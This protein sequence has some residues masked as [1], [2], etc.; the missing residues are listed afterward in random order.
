[1]RLLTRVMRL[2][3]RMLLGWPTVMSCS[4]ASILSLSEPSK[5]RW[6][7]SFMRKRL[8]SIASFLSAL[9]FKA[10]CAFFTDLLSF[11]FMC[12]LSSV[13]RSMSWCSSCAFAAFASL[14]RS[15]MT[16]PSIRTT[17]W[18]PMPRVSGV[19]TYRIFRSLNMKNACSGGTSSRRQTLFMSTC[20]GVFLRNMTG[21][22]WPRTSLTISWSGSPYLAFF[23]SASRAFPS[24]SVAVPTISS[25]T[26]PSSLG[27][28]AGA[29][30][31]PAWL[32][33]ALASFFISSSCF[34][35]FQ[36][37]ISAV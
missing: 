36:G 32:S 35:S 27:S 10:C 7:M 5:R 11:S 34:F 23:A 37:S 30:A 22:S 29:S 9:C 21:V 31:W 17:S 4:G 12:C 2:L 26:P 19:S 33:C 1:M 20:I 8:I 3:M 15:C 13:A 16:A 24:S 18:S 28:P 6:T 14:S 25:W